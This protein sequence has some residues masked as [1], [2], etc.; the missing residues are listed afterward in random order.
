MHKADA[1]DML[2]AMTNAQRAQFV[3]DSLGRATG[4]DL[5]TEPVSGAR[6]AWFGAP[7]AL[8]GRVN[9]D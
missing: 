7:G 4:G 5:R 3:N 6:S 9:R 1:G 8:C 2:G